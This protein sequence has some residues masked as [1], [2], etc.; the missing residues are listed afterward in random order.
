L[1]CI[2]PDVKDV[3]YKLASSFLSSID[4]EVEAVDGGGIGSS[5][6]FVQ[7]SKSRANMDHPFSKFFTRNKNTLLPTASGDDEIVFSL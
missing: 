1:V 7:L 3:I 2:D 5:F 4:L 6:R